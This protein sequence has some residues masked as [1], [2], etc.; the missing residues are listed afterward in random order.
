MNP[1]S[2]RKARIIS[3]ISANLIG[4]VLTAAIQL[5]GIPVFLSCWGKEYY[6]EWLILFTIPSY[7]GMSDLGLGTVATTEMA[8]CVS[9]GET[10]RAAQIFRASFWGI[11]MVGAGLCSVFALTL[12]VLPWH[13]WLHLQ[14]F[15]PPETVL[16]LALLTAYVFGAIVLTLPLGVYRSTGRYGRGQMVSNLFR[17]AEFLAVLAVVASGKGATTAA[18]AMVAVRF[19][20]VG[21]VWMEAKKLATWL[22]LRPLRWEWPIIRPLAMPSLSM[23]T[24][25]AGQSL[26]SQGLVTLIGVM[27]GAANVVVF[28]TVRTLC[29][30]ARQVI[31]AIN[32]SV[33]SEF[34]I[35]IGNG[36]LATARRLHRRTVQANVALT[37]LAVI[38]LKVLG[39]W[40]L[41][42]WT[43]GQ[44][45]AEEPFF[46]LYLGYVLFNS[47]WIGSWSML[48][49][50]NRHE[51][52]TRYFLASS[53]ATLALAYA[54]VG[55]WGVAVVPAV[56]LVADG[57]FAVFVFQ[58]SA[59]VL[60]QPV[61]V[62]FK[63]LLTA[64][65]KR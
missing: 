30:F 51:G 29:N 25:Y 21:F 6:G 36:D 24:V 20:Y 19:F 47:L 57:V 18:A 23:T 61:G 49:G 56:L 9:N 32:L 3:G 45:A 27:T 40:A 46:S 41:L 2:T 63:D 52:L 58:K 11:A 12:G 1:H 10:E 8:M 16:T 64:R 26:V 4:Q 43:K 48:L 14:Q 28:S 17:L 62:F 39:G 60:R 65:E 54:G 55:A 37:L 33:F 15:A 59:V 53:I 34:S 5:V 38:G 42:H 44:V 50:C 13:D 7:L 35:S 22:R 31:G